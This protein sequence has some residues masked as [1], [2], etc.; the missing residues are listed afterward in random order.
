[1]TSGASLMSD[2]GTCIDGTITCDAHVDCVAKAVD[3]VRGGDV[4][5]LWMCGC[6]DEEET[7]L[8]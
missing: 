6:S 2:C 3:R 1:M 7:C 5:C 8:S 4:R